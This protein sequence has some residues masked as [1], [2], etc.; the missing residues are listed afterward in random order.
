MEKRVKKNEAEIEW[1]FLHIHNNKWQKRK[2]DILFWQLEICLD[3][4]SFCL[5]ID[6]KERGRDFVRIY[7][8]RCE[9]IPCTRM[10]RADRNMYF[11]EWKNCLLT[12][13]RTRRKKNCVQA[14]EENKLKRR[15]NRVN[16]RKFAYFSFSHFRRSF[17]CFDKLVCLGLD[18]IW[19]K[20][21]KTLRKQMSIATAK[22]TL[23][24]KT[25]TKE[26]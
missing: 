5:Q 10:T 13:T 14:N 23:E 17:F 21:H 25:R 15:E 16:K 22:P 18:V 3:L 9:F 20:A 26:K 19:L 4:C 24:N 6:R 8:W 1:T 7:E 11:N 2:K 12:N